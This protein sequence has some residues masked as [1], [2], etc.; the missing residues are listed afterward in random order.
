MV[1][2]FLADLIELPLRRLRSKL[3][4]VPA[5]HFFDF[6]VLMR[7]RCFRSSG[8]GWLSS[9]LFFADKIQFLSC[10]ATEELLA[11]LNS[12]WWAEALWDR[13]TS[14]LSFHFHI[15]TARER[16]AKDRSARGF[17]T[18]GG[19]E[20]DGNFVQ[21][22][23]NLGQIQFLIIRT[24][25]HTEDFPF[26]DYSIL[27]DCLELYRSDFPPSSSRPHLS[28]ARVQSIASRRTAG[29][30]NFSWLDLPFPSYFRMLRKQQ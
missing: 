17:L 2:A 24:L 9:F 8:H 12:F 26:A 14:L 29:V 3:P 19:L 7:L 1:R 30:M 13:H 16:E 11:R 10:K 28:F 18:R 22:P 25:K 6:V 15:C 5:S 4:V 20:S 27:F 21:P 23:S